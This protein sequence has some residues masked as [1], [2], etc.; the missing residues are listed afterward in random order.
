MTQPK[1]PRLLIISED[2]PDSYSPAGERIHHLALAGQKKFST[3]TV[4]TLRQSKTAQNTQ[5]R[6]S[7]SSAM[8]Y[9]VNF[10]RALPF[11]LVSFFDPVKMHM[12]LIHGL[13]LS[14][15]TKPTYIIASMP[16]LETGTAA[17]FIAKTR[18]AQLIIDI[19]DDWESAVGTQLK[20]YFPKQL[21]RFL[22]AT[23]QKIYTSAQAVFAVTEIISDTLRK[24][25][26]TTHLSLIPNGADSTVFKPQPEKMRTEI[27]TQYALPKDKIIMV[28]SGSGINPYYRLDLVL[29][30]VKQLPTTTA[31]KPFFV[32]YL[33]NGHA[34]LNKLK[35]QLQ[36]PD[37]QLE[38]RTPLPRRQLAQVTSA[39]DV[40]LVPFD[41]K[42]YLL[43]ARSTKMYEYLSCGLA[44]IS[45]GPKGG[46]LDS[47]FSTHSELGVFML[48]TV[49]NFAQ[50]LAAT[51]EKDKV[52]L[53][54]DARSLRHEF[55]RNNYDRQVIMEKALDTLLAQQTE[56]LKAKTI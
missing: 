54:D 21:I 44:V 11:P 53:N 26:V 13:L 29:A 8:L 9:S 34:Q 2:S 6:Q 46:E 39:C 22:S 43:C 52:L 5:K 50:V 7:K 3:V 47:F 33:Y 20:R 30:A 41:A 40:G 14:H 35:Q 45:S 25:G 15:K 42:P 12:L 17:W 24:K 1:Q 19:R 56:T 27:R 38:I 36:I 32:F 4:L 48:P 18:K 28:Y 16:P 51:S 10:T 49:V 55:I 23:A 31:H 37:S